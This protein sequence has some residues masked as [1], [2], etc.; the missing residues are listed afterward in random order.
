MSNDIHH[1]TFTNDYDVI[2][3]HGACPDGSASAAVLKKYASCPDGVKIVQVYDRLMTLNDIITPE[4]H[5]IFCDIILS[6]DIAMDFVVN[7]AKK[8]SIIDHHITS[9]DNIK[10]YIAVSPREMFVLFT[11][12]KCATMLCYDIASGHDANDVY[13]WYISSINARDLWIYPEGHDDTEKYKATS[14]AMH[15]KGLSTDINAL[16]EFMSNDSNATNAM[17]AEFVTF[18]KAIGEYKSQELKKYKN[19]ITTAT[20]TSKNLN[21][22]FNV[23]V[24]SAPRYMSS[25]VANYILNNTEISCDFVCVYA[26]VIKENEFWISLRA[27]KDTNLVD[28]MK[29]TPLSGGHPQAYGVTYKNLDDFRRDFVV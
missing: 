13:P 7:T 24:L 17:F 9:Y 15:T 16:V 19:M 5:V 20:Y 11:T 29:G 1:G 12:S 3:T 2:V 21:K 25:D 27:R 23:A 10:K 6:N 26:Y 18:G 8:V 4:S 14:D 28:I 22:T